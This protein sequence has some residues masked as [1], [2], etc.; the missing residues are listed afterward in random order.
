MEKTCTS[1]HH[2]RCFEDIKIVDPKQALVF[3]LDRV[4]ANPVWA[5]RVGQDNSMYPAIKDNSPVIL[6]KIVEVPSETGRNVSYEL[7]AT[8]EHFGEHGAG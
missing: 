8:V 3:Y 7:V 5:T 1:C 6:D 4:K 2:G